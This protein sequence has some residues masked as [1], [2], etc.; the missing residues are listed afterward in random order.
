MSDKASERMELEGI[1]SHSGNSI[2]KLVAGF[3]ILAGV[4][5]WAYWDTVMDLMAIWQR[6][7]E[8][9]S[10]MLVPFLALYILWSR[11]DDLFKCNISPSLW[12]IAGLLV[13][14]AMRG[15]GLFLWFSSVERLSLIVSISSLILLLFGWKFFW[16]T[17][18][19]Q[20]FLFLM[21]PLPNRVHSAIM[22]PLQDLATTSAVFCLEMLGYIVIREGNVLHLGDTTVAVA[23]AC[24]GLRMVMA[25][26][27]IICLVVLIAK[28]P[29]WEKLI[30]LL[31]SLP[32]ALLCNT[33][34]L[35]V[36]AIAFTMIGGE[37][38]EMLFHDW[39][40]YAM[41]PIALGMVVFELYILEKLTTVQE[42]T[43]QE[44]VVRSAR[45]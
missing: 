43:P 21:I 36:T 10:G 3:A 40:G 4:F 38:W 34:R 31:S 5:L 22:L 25:F 33:I 2:V 19:V 15:F 35:T 16:K 42:S 39:G 27:V 24:N 29:W 44:V 28:R 17:F 13:A 9:S 18:T 1:K 7:D 12:G 32:V 41:M 23:E 14:Q 20:L 37:Y 11:R 30:V 6:S 26:F 45:N 8:Y